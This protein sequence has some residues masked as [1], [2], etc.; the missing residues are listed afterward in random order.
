MLVVSDR[1][2]TKG[3]FFVLVIVSMAVSLGAMLLVGEWACAGQKRGSVRNRK[4]IS[5]DLGKARV[6]QES[7]GHGGSRSEHRLETVDA[8]RSLCQ[9]GRSLESNV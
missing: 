4:E 2:F 9:A 3:L 7:R 8:C 6:G 5:S 1:S